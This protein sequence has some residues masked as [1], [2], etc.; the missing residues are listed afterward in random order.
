MLINKG[1]TAL[2][3]IFNSMWKSG[4]STMWINGGKHSE[5]AEISTFPPWKRSNR[6]DLMWKSRSMHA[7]RKE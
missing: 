4:E 5:N 1:H 6:P 3:L 2:F 7:K